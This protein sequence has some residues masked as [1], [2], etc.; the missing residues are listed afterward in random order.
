MRSLEVH[1]F[2]T[3]QDIDLALEYGIALPEHLANN[4]CIQCFDGV[5]HQPDHEFRS[6]V[7]VIDGID[8]DWLLCQDCASPILIYFDIN[9][10]AAAKGTYLRDDL[11]IDLDDLEAF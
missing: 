3:E 11:G 9:S 1:V 4:R 5:G 6:F 7:L 10:P 8:H 2:E